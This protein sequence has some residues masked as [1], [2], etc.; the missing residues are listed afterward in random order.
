VIDVGTGEDPVVRLHVGEFDGDYACL[1]YCWGGDQFKTTRATLE[2]LMAEIPTA[3]LSLTVADAVEVTRRLGLRYLWVDALCIV[4]DSDEDKAREI[5]RMGAIYK[6]AAVTIA[7]ATARAASEGFLRSQRTVRSAAV[8]FWLP[9]G[10]VGVVRVAYTE[11]FDFGEDRSHEDHPLDGRGWCLQES[12]L[13]PRLLIFSTFNVERRCQAGRIEFTGGGAFGKQHSISATLRL[14]PGIFGGATKRQ[15][16][17]NMLDAT[18]GIDDH[19][20]RNIW[21]SIVCR[22]TTRK[23]TDP[24]D[25]LATLA[26]I[27]G[28]L[29]RVWGD[30]YLFG[31]WTKMLPWT[32]SWT[33]VQPGSR[34]ALAPTWSWASVT[35]AV[36]FESVHSPKLVDITVEPAS[37]PGLPRL[38]VSGTLVP[39]SELPTA[40]LGSNDSLDI[41]LDLDE[42]CVEDGCSYLVLDRRTGWPMGSKTF[43]WIQ[44]TYLILRQVDDGVYSRVGVA[45]HEQRFQTRGLLEADSAWV[46]L[47]K[48]PTV[49]IRLV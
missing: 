28:E 12:L 8:R 32:M 17:E 9:N 6:N 11:R 2:K 42:P 10:D 43:K 27:A 35:S 25:R 16:L 19:H 36:G 31:M 49:R 41:L 26:G 29:Q 23:L 20:P 3:S 13:S 48:G 40:S 33:A 15:L 46:A 14:P 34:L 18:S 30:E 5:V 4:Q 45:R 39:S 22:Y 24:N 7:A 47:S 44:T 21:R 38:A 1:S 37:P